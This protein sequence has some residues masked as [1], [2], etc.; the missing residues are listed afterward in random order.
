[1]PHFFYKWIFGLKN[2]FSE[3]NATY[4]YIIFIP[5]QGVPKDE[6]LANRLLN[7]LMK[8]VFHQ[9]RAVF[10]HNLEIIK[11]LVECWKDCLSIPYRY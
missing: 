1:M 11:T 9:K 5:F 4:S 7:F 8:H 3:R 6:V 10:S 2:A